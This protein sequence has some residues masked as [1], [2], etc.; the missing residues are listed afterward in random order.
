MPCSPGNLCGRGAQQ[1]GLCMR[2]VVLGASGGVGK[3]LLVEA[4]AAG[5]D[6]V[7]VG[8]PSSDIEQGPWAVERGVLDDETFLTRCLQGADA[9]LSGLGSRLPGIAPWHRLE[10]PGFLAASTKALVAAA[11]TTGTRRI[12]VVSAAGVG[13]SFPHVPGF[14]KVFI[15]TTALRHAYAELAQMERILL[16]SGLEVLIA[17]P[18]GL[19]HGPKT[20]RGK[21]VTEFAGRN[22]ISRADVAAWMASFVSGPLPTQRTPLVGEAVESDV[23]GR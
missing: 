12:V 6:V 8:R 17:R 1:R 13:D 10:Q 14:F 19:S 5:H 18:P 16:D 2:I 4:H 20:G 21:I 15:K 11:R 22:S 9:V 7:A 23:A 3:Q